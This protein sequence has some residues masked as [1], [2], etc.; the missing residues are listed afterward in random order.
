MFYP[1]NGF[2]SSTT[3]LSGTLYILFSRYKLF[4]R[5][6]APLQV[7]NRVS[8]KLMLLLYSYSLYNNNMSKSLTI[9]IPDDELEILKQYCD[10][11]N[12]TQTEILRNYIRT[13]K[14][15]LKVTN[16]E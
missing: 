9:R 10:Q 8:E 15:K 7:T 5:I 4:P 2:V 3:F 6:S 13:L 12:R 1:E 11:T 14:G 16:A